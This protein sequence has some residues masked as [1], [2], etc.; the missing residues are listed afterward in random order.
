MDKQASD[1]L[2]LDLRKVT[3][4]ADYF[5]LCSGETERQVNAIVDAIEEAVGREDSESPRREG[6]AGSGWVILDYGD[7]VVHVFAPEEREYYRLDRVWR[8]AAPV[9]QIQ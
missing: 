4:F 2:L 7:V 8:D 9:V 1:I 3:D 5:V 6:D